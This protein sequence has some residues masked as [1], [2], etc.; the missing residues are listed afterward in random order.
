M[1]ASGRASARGRS[2]CEGEVIGPVSTCEDG[3]MGPVPTC[4]GE[5]T[6]CAGTGGADACAGGYAGARVGED[7][8]GGSWAGSATVG[9]DGAA[10]VAA[11]LLS[12]QRATIQRP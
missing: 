11:P 6:G 3:V 1:A 9:T 4:E 12:S 7:V 10:V 2:T 5:V 8:A